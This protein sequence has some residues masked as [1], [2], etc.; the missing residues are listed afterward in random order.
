[1]EKY[2]ARLVNLVPDAH[3]HLLGLSVEEARARLASGDPDRVRSIA[4]SFAL[5]AR[6]G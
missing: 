5:V 3:Q 1:M 6:R 2:V 4:G